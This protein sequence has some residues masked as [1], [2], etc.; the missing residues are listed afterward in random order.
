MKKN[1]LLK[2]LIFIVAAVSI[3]CT[4]TASQTANTN[5]INQDQGK[6]ERPG[7]SLYYLSNESGSFQI[8]KTDLESNSPI[9]ITNAPGDINDYSVSETNGHIAYILKNQLYLQSLNNPSVE[10]I[11]DGGSQDPINPNQLYTTTLSGLAWTHDGNS[12]AYGYNGINLYLVEQNTHTKIISNEISQDPNGEI[13][14]TAVYQPISWSPN[15]TQILVNIES[16][17]GWEIASLHISNTEIVKLGKL[18]VCCTML[19]LE[20]N[21][22]VLGA[23]PYVGFTFPGLWH[24]NSNTGVETNLIPTTSEEGTLNFVGWPK[25]ISNGSL[26][27]FYANTAA[28][29]ETSPALI[30]VESSFSNLS[31]PTTLRPENWPVIEALWAKDGS[32]AIIVQTPLGETTTPFSGPIL[33][34]DAAG[35]PPLP[36]ATNGYNLQWG[37]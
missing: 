30:M 26:R 19:W 7:I 35:N 4:L 2:F 12:L 25:D 33:L 24:Y 13:I 3:S 8:W 6:E 15:N 21:Q 17:E 5:E 10:L 32:F 36:L 20:D 27:F 28:Y 37:P 16:L 34:V 11:F 23:N 9:Q 22:S 18:L 1:S 14:P 29:P 31:N